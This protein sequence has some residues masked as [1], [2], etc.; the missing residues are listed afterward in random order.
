[1]RKIDSVVWAL[2]GAGALAAACV[3]EG[4][5]LGFNTSPTRVVQVGVYLDR[6]GSRTPV[7][8]EGV[9]NARLAIL[10][11]GSS[12]TFKTATTAG[13]AA[14]GVAFFDDIPLGQ[15]RLAVDARTLGDSI[16]VQAIE[17]VPDGT[18]TD[19][20]AVT[21][22]S[23]TTTVRVRLGYP[24]VTIRQARALPVGRRVFIRGVILA[25]VQ[26]FRDTTSHIADSSGALR[27]T[28]VT[29]LGGLT[30]NNP[31][32]S[33]SVLGFTSSR[34]GQPTLDNSSVA[35]FAT[36]TAP[37]PLPVGT[38]TA[39][40][41]A[42]GVLDAQLVRITGAII[43]DTLTVAPDFQFRA[44][45]GTGTL[46]VILDASINFPRTAFA[47]GR[48]M[49]AVGVLVPDGV[50]GWVFKPRGLGDVVLN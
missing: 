25:G 4:S 1:M 21:F 41:A 39:A 8:A 50:G 17:L 34:A 26:S 5:D 45:D 14:L 10:P 24:E 49:N 11:R 31:G 46:T 7:P 12:D 29:L 33:V 9:A 28:R 44:S 6:D 30:G 3:N 35:R 13:G 23:D 22:P 18:E 48:S 42:N 43:S 37:V 15:W 32:D 40:N 36:T 16:Q 19:E 2:I 47:P 27:L 38:G 20:F